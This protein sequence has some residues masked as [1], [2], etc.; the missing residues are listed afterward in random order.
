MSHWVAK[1]FIGSKNGVYTL[2]S[3]GK[4]AMPEWNDEIIGNYTT[5]VF[6]TEEDA[7]N[8][9]LATPRPDGYLPH[10]CDVFAEYE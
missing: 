2:R 4:G 1:A 6:E 10:F 9:G 5:L 8:A 3:L 7:I